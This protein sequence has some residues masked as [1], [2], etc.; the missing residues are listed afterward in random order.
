MLGLPGFRAYCRFEIL[1]GC[2][3]SQSG[4]TRGSAE[5]CTS[6]EGVR[7]GRLIHASNMRICLGVCYTNEQKK[8]TIRSPK[9]KYCELFS[10]LN[11]GSALWMLHKLSQATTKLQAGWSNV[12]A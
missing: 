12:V 11:R 3:R 6:F 9:E 10:L 2:A 8:I 5:G 7:R 1:Y 4:S